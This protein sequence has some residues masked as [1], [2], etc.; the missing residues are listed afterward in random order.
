M[1]KLYRHQQSWRIPRQA[2]ILNLGIC[3]SP[4]SPTGDALLTYTLCLD[5]LLKSVNKSTHYGAAEFVSRKNAHP[6]VTHR[7]RVVRSHDRDGEDLRRKREPSPPDS[8]QDLRQ[9]H[10]SHGVVRQAARS[11]VLVHDHGR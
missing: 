7:E 3:S 9:G 5:F 1:Q 4:I 2:A 10:H 11:H 6:C 8:Q